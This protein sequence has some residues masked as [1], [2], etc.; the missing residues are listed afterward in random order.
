MV[1]P[2]Q[3]AS[4]TMTLEKKK[5]DKND[6]FGD[7]ICRPLSYVLTVPFLM[8]GIRAN[9]ISLLSV[10]VSAFGFLLLGFSPSKIAQIAGVMLFFV[11]SILDRNR[12]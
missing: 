8:A 1:T 12:L 4:K 11:W 3:I 6:L 2:K 5:A 9:T 7:R 10:I